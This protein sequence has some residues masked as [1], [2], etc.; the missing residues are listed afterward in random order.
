MS[1]SDTYVGKT[2]QI[3]NLLPGL[4]LNYLTLQTDFN[5]YKSALFCNV[6]WRA[7]KGLIIGPLLKAA[8]SKRSCCQHIQLADSL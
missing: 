8:V 7:T 2:M 3:V 4:T 5:N 1:M 6:Q